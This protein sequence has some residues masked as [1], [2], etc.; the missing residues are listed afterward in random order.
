MSKQ[1]K[2]IDSES[3]LE[4]PERLE[5]WL[6]DNDLARFVVDTEIH[7]GTGFR[8]YQSSYGFS[9]FYVAWFGSCSG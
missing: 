7:G 4:L 1:F 5:D 3:P 6:E 2:N 9:T 8:H